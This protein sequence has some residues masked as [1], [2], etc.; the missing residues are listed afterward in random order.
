MNDITGIK[1]FREVGSDTLESEVN[2][3][4]RSLDSTY[5][6]IDVRLHFE[7]DHTTDIPSAV[8]T[9]YCSGS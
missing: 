4:L 5:T 7:G 9:Y 8:V 3:W 1:I 2:F 6:V